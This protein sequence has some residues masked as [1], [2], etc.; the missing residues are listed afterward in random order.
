MGTLC[1]ERFLGFLG[2]AGQDRAQAEDHT[3]GVR[4][5]ARILLKEPRVSQAP[6][7]FSQEG[8]NLAKLP[9]RAT[10]PQLIDFL[11]FWLLLL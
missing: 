7:L 10:S 8:P 9:Q 1:E 5:L 2:Q 4:K 11:M 3:G 6:A